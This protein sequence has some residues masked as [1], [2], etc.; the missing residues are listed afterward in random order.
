MNDNDISVKLKEIK[1][2]IEELLPEVELINK[3][4]QKKKLVVKLGADPTAPDLHLGHTVVLNKLK[5][6]QDFGYTVKFLIGDFTAMVGDPTGKNV[7]RPP[8]TRE[9][10]LENAKTYEKQIFKILDPSKT[11]VVFNSEWLTALGAEGMLRLSSSQTVARMLERD[12]FKK[13][14][15]EGTAISIHEFLYPLLQG[16]DSVALEA[17]IEIGGTDQKFNLLMGR[18]LQKHNSKEPQ[19]ILT[20][21]LL[22]GLDGVKK[23]SKSANNYIGIDESPNDMFGKLMSIS[24]ELMWQYFDLLSF[25]STEEISKL[26]SAVIAGKNPKDVKVLLAKEIIARFHSEEEADKAELNFIDQFK[27]GKIPDDIQEF[28]LNLNLTMPQILKLSNLCQSTSEAMRMIKQ[29]A[30]KIDG[31]KI[32]STTASLEKGEYVIQVGKRKFAKV[33]LS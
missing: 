4:K 17:D 19:V 23:M 13:R 7:T 20:M 11:D 28:K 29:G 12:D 31:E 21:P 8:L 24:D 10:V 30:L 1:K 2:G 22:I 33:F 5:L 32:A 27:K 6:L 25:K 14:Y 15:Q 18:E 26:R 16:Y 3:L 9:Q